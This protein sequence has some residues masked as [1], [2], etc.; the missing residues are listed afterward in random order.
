MDKKYFPPS[1]EI[2][3]WELDVL[4]V[5]GDNFLDWN[6]FGNDSQEGTEV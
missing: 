1:V 6:D 5:S 2:K 4:L 3:H